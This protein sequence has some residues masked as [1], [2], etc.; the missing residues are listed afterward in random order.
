[1]DSLASSLGSLRFPSAVREAA[2]LEPRSVSGGLVPGFVFIV[3]GVFVAAIG[4]A[5]AFPLAKLF[6]WV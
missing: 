3:Q 6:G 5:V 4:G 2:G 1:M